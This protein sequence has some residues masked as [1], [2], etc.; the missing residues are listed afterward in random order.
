[1]LRNELS[2]L[3][4]G[5][6]D[7]RSLCRHGSSPSRKQAT[8]TAVAI[9]RYHRQ[10]LLPQIG[11]AGQRK[12]AGARVLLVGCGALGSTIAEQLAR[13][14]IGHLRNADRDIVELTNLQR[15]VLFD[16]SDAAGGLPKAVAAANRLSKINST[17]TIEPRVVDVDALN[18]EQLVAGCDMI[19]DGTDNVA[20]R[21]LVNDVAVKHTIPWIYGACVGTEGRVMT[22]RPGAGAC[23][24]CIFPQPPNA[25]ELATCDTAGVLGP[26]ASVVGAMQ[27]LAAIKLLSGNADAIA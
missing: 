2:E 11:E 26:V 22:I 3:L 5:G 14:G 9:D 25:S 24:R 15:Q 21:Y 7:F 27:A 19:L 12:L 13:A 16:D 20:T 10:T 23:L 18:V 6:H 8:I 17:I 4:R 1:M